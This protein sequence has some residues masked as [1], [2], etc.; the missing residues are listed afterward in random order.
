[1]RRVVDFVSVSADDD[2]DVLR[3]H[4]KLFGSSWRM[5][6]LSLVESIPDSCVG[7][8]EGTSNSPNMIA[9]EPSF[10]TV[11]ELLEVVV[12]SKFPSRNFF[13]SKNSCRSFSRDK[14]SFSSWVVSVVAALVRVVVSAGME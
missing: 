5:I 10:A 2:S 6:W 1:M 9:S 7:D 13:S 3:S 12:L 4:G 11:T 8:V 14:S